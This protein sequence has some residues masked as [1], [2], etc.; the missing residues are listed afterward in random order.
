MRY[1]RNNPE[2]MENIRYWLYTS[3]RPYPHENSIYID[4]KYLLL[5]LE[6]YDFYNYRE[7]VAMG[8]DR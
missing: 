6:S 1:W 4:D 7:L 5:I 2:N 3:A 8:L